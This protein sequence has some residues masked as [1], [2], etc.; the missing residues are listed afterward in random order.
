MGGLSMRG[1]DFANMRDLITFNLSIMTEQQRRE[2]AAIVSHGILYRV[3]CDHDHELSSSVA[4]SSTGE[5]AY[6]QDQRFRICT[7]PAYGHHQTC[8]HLAS[9]IET[10]DTQQTKQKIQELTECT[11]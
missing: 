5:K 2:I 4:L 8:W 10:R 6:F 11:N 1:A 9:I 7:C 3:A